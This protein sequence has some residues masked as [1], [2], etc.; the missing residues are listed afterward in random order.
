MHVEKAKERI[1][2]VLGGILCAILLL[3]ADTFVFGVE[4]VGSAVY[5]REALSVLEQ[6]GIMPFAPYKKGQEDWICAQLLT[7]PNVE[8][9]SIKKSGGY[10]YVEM[11]LSPFFQDSVQTESMTAKHNGALLSIAVLRGE[12]RVKIG[13]EIRVGDVLVENAFSIEGGGQVRV[14]PIAR[15]VIACVYEKEISAQTQEEAFAAAYLELGLTDRDSI[16]ERTIEESSDE[17]GLF[18]VKIQYTVIETVNM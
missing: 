5:K 9:C 4:F 2:M 18:H 10:V 3:A 8:Y 13:Q 15:A 12:S 11:R 1:G 16:V 17:Q 7:L 14:E 6:S